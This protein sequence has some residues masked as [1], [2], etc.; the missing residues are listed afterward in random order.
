MATVASPMLDL[1]WWLFM[2]RHH[3]TGYGIPHPDGM[4]TREQ[5][6]RRYQE[7]TGHSTEHIDFYEALSALRG[8][9]IMIRLATMMVEANMLPADADTLHNNP[10][11]RILAELT[12]QPAPDGQGLT[13]PVARA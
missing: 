6:I 12:G 3:T 5:T 13:G 11:S 9:V 8:A 4:P 2:Q 7:L 10:G 1:G